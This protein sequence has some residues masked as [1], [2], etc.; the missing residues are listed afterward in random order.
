MGVADLVGRVVRGESQCKD[1][2]PT[3]NMHS[4]GTQYLADGSAVGV[5]WCRRTA[6]VRK[7]IETWNKGKS[8]LDPA[9]SPPLGMCRR[10]ETG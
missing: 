10:E 6:S 3:T 5:D 2:W 8:K 7:G 1:G 9:E 4:G